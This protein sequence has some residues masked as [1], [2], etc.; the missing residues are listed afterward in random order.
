MKCS[1]SANADCDLFD[2]ESK[3]ISTTQ[4]KIKKEGYIC[5]ISSLI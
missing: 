4:F 1:E 3:I 5:K 2:F